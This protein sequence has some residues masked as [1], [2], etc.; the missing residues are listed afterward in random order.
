MSQET[1]TDSRSRPRPAHGF[2]P[3]PPEGMQSCSHRAF[4]PARLILDIWLF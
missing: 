1:Q 3:E 4:S 2:S